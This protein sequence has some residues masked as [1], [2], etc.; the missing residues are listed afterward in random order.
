MGVA[1]I[2][3]KVLSYKHEFDPQ[4]PCRKWN[5]LV[6]TCTEDV[7]TDMAL[8]LM[9]S[10]SSITG[11]LQI[12]ERDRASKSRQLVHEERDPGLTVHPSTKTPPHIHNAKK[13]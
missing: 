12:P 13:G 4:H 9:A 6:C 1:E 11:K 8:E 10:P 5:P 3:G 7:E 2:V